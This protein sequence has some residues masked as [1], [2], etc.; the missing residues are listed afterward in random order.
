MIGIVF[1]MLFS[2]GLIPKFILIN[3]IGLYNTRWVIII[4]TAA[5]AFQIIIARVFIETT[6]PDSLPES[7]YIDGASDIHVFSKIV[8]PLCK[9]I[10]AVLIIFSAVEY[11]NQYFQSLIYQPNADLHPITMLLRGILIMN[12]QLSN[13]E[14]ADSLEQ[15]MYSEKIKYATIVITI[16]PIVLVYPFIQKHFIKGFML[17]AIKA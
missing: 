8:V 2:G 3:Q 9:P 4:P 12:Q 7:A 13:L 10:L 15:L 11:W 17:G 5:K 14:G 1:T 6:V 16:L